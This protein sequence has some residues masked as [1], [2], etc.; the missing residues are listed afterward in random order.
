MTI[1][2]KKNMLQFT[3]GENPTHNV[4]QLSHVYHQLQHAYPHNTGPALS[5]R[6]NLDWALLEN[7]LNNTDRSPR[8]FYHVRQ[9][10]E[11]LARECEAHFGPTR[12]ETIM[13][14]ATLA[15]ASLYSDDAE[16]AEEIIVD[17]VFPRIRQNFPENHPYTWEAK[18]RHAYLLL[19]LARRDPGLTAK[20]KLQQ[21][22]QLLR[23]IV[24][25]RRRVLG[26]SNPKTRH[27]FQMLKTVLEK[28]GKVNDANSLWKW[29]QHQM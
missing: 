22:E 26:E 13:A 9:D 24:L 28:Q 18:H 16:K 29:C 12:I 19:Q 17:F 15:R 3:E 10:L 27:S 11:E 7:A 14:Y 8:H 5:A 23:E 4:N 6:Y 2:F 1:S 25:S 20:R 21:A